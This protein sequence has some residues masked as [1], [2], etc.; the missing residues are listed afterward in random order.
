M[1]STACHG[2]WNQAITASLQAP[3]LLT[4]DDVIIAKFASCQQG[5][6]GGPKGRNCEVAVYREDQG[7]TPIFFDGGD[8]QVV[9]MLSCVGAA[10]LEWISCLRVVRAHCPSYAQDD[11]AVCMA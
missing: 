9:T 5:P 1:E 7:V 10:Y 8:P 3:R 2:V 4:A 11:A 6:P